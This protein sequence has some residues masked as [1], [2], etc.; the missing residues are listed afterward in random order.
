MKRAAERIHEMCAASKS[1]RT[2]QRAALVKGGHLENEATDILFDGHNF[3]IFRAPK[4]AM[5]DTH[6]TGCALSSAIAALLAQGCEIPEAVDRAKRYLSEILRAAP[7]IGR[8]ARPLNTG[9]APRV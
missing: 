9:I 6:G 4:I 8:G 2:A 3:H 1:K 5:R 7:D